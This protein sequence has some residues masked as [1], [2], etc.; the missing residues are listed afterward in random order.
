MC[1][2]NILAIAVL[3]S[4][5]VLAQNGPER[6]GLYSDIRI[7]N[8]FCHFDTL[9]GH[10]AGD[11]IWFAFQV[12]AAE[13]LGQ[14]TAWCAEN[15]FRI[16][17]RPATEEDLGYVGPGH[18]V[19]LKCKGML[20]SFEHMEGRYKAVEAIKLKLGIKDCGMAGIKVRP[21]MKTDCAPAKDAP[22]VKLPQRLD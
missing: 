8:Q 20:G 12:P 21:G 18:Q 13:P 17:T 5:K 22:V 3:L 6:C 10:F 14:L 9:N 15:G 7:K 16:T 1:R 2:L 19:S 4:I 11:S